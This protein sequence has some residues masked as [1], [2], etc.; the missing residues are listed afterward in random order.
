MAPQTARYG[1]VLLPGVFQCHACLVS[2]PLSG[3][4]V[5]RPEGKPSLQRRKG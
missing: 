5:D 2:V 3:L 1:F 4:L